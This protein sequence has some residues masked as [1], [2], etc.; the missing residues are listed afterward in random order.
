MDIL[1]MVRSGIYLGRMLSIFDVGLTNRPDAIRRKPDSGGK[2]WSKIDVFW[3]F[4][5]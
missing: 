2:K 5:E 4:Y 3:G 1:Y